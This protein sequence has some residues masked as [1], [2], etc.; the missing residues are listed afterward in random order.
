MSF[1]WLGPVRP[2]VL[3]TRRP[4]P[5]PRPRRRIVANARA[6][7]DRFDD[8]RFFVHHPA[9]GDHGRDRG[10][11]GYRAKHPEAVAAASSPVARRPSPVARRPSPVARRPRSMGSIDRWRPRSTSMSID[12]SIVIDRSHRS[13]DRWRSRSPSIERAHRSDRPS[14]RSPIGPIV[15]P[16][17]SL[18]STAPLTRACD[19][20]PSWMV[21]RVVDST[22]TSLLARA[23]RAS[24]S[25]SSPIASIASSIVFVLHTLRHTRP[26][27]VTYATRFPDGRC[28]AFSPVRATARHGARHF[29]SNGDDA[30]A[31]ARAIV[32][33]RLHNRHQRERAGNKEREKRPSPRNG[34]ERGRSRRST[35]HRARCNRRRQ[36]AEGRRRR[37]R[38]RCD[39]N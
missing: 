24:T 32:Q 8:Q 7:L 34:G 31:R 9:R 2:V 36:R 27:V 19:R 29:A 20:P 35:R 17:A 4:R 14:V 37:T 23:R 6:H 21:R 28:D 5:R 16:S 25:K 11:P 12:R 18:T 38:G 3:V 30:R 15:R 39:T 33:G 26:T 13:I 22:S 10:R 1:P